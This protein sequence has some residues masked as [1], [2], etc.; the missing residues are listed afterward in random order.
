MVLLQNDV[1]TAPHVFKRMGTI[2]PIFD[3]ASILMQYSLA[4]LEVEKISPVE[5]YAVF[6]AKI[7]SINTAVLVAL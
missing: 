4:E 3:G 6:D 1:V 5:L 2:P 7:T